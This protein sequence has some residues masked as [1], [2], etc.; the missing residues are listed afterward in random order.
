MVY[1]NVSDL[2]RRTEG[3]H[4]GEKM[5]IKRLLKIPDYLAYR[6]NALYI[7]VLLNRFG[8]EIIDI[9]SMKKDYS[10]YVK[11]N[12]NNVVKY[13][14]RH[15]KY[16]KEKYGNRYCD[17]QNLASIDK[18]EIRANIDLMLTDVS[19]KK[20][21]CKA[22][23]GGST[24][25]PFEF[26]LS[27]QFDVEHQIF[28][29]KLLGW[30]KKDIILTIAGTQIDSNI[31]KDKKYYIKKDRCKNWAYGHYY[32]SS[33]YLNQN[34]MKNYVENIEE[35][36]PSFIRGYS[37]AIADIA[38]YLL[39]NNIDLKIKLKA[40]EITSENIS[41]D[42]IDMIKR[43]F[44]TEVY[45]QYGQTEAC[46]FGFTFNKEFEYIFS[47]FYGYTEI[48]DENDKHVKEGEM[49]EI[50]VT[51]FSNYAMPFIRYR[52]GDLAR[53]KKRLNGVTYVS[54]IMG[55]TQDFIYNDEGK[56]L[57][58]AL[59]FG[60]HYSAFAHIDR[61]QI[62]QYEVGRISMNIVRGKG[63]SKNDENEIYNNFKQIG[64]I[65]T[66]FEYVEKIQ[67]TA[68]GK[69]KFLIQNIEEADK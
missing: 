21:I 5:Y 62:I 48:L 47:P 18:E 25:Q 61:W 33:L 54:E 65:E 43:A 50:V 39:L 51:S 53:F 17:I 41:A 14:L 32:M 27:P 19:W 36:K 34:T 6:F 22:N 29:W 15:C 20:I 64:K 2:G 42:Q 67:R 31:I 4:I 56:V 30:R 3:K 8:K 57:L 9:Q 28:L 11:K 46:A 23:T 59:V 10:T 60:M 44:K 16:Y 40:I 55:R 12:V 38:K 26:F 58:V 35:I 1:P 49:G 68:A 45:G 13:S 63:F 24:G 37:S 66:R 7:K 69:S 52:T